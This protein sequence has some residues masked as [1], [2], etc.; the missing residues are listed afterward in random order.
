MPH[1]LTEADVHRVSAGASDEQFTDVLAVEEPLE[2]RIG[3]PVNGKFEHRA[4][5]ITMRTP[6]EDFELATGFLFTE[7]ILKS[8]D[9]IKA[10]KHCGKPAPAATTSLSEPGAVAT[11][12]LYHAES[13][14]SVIL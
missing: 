4:I 14:F 8:P 9:Q 13:S 3:L 10:I 2:I 5:S 7:G 1:G 6:G 11:G 12:F